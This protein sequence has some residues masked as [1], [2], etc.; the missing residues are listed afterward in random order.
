MLASIFNVCAA[1]ALDPNVCVKLKDAGLG[2][3]VRAPVV[4]VKVT[5]SVAEVPPAVTVILP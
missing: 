3:M 4:I 1:G 2:V 5:A